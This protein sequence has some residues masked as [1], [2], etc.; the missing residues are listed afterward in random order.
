MWETLQG[1]GSPPVTATIDLLLDAILDVSV[2]EPPNGV[3]VDPSLTVIEQQRMLREQLLAKLL[4]Q[5]DLIVQQRLQECL[6]EAAEKESPLL[7]TYL[8]VCA[9]T[10]MYLCVCQAILRH[11]RCVS[12]AASSRA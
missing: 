2:L 1:M 5:M 7:P 3:G 10:Q 4:Y 11:F 8:R 9:C 6:M 12:L